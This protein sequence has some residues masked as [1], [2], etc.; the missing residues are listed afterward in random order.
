VG[1]R[2]PWVGEHTCEVLRDEL[3]LDEG[4]LRR[5][6]DEGVIGS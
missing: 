4:E 1:G 2:V 3:G 6:L 5:L